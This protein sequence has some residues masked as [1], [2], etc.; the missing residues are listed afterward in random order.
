MRFW[1]AGAVCLLTV[2]LLGLT[3]CGGDDAAEPGS[4]ESGPP[5]S[6]VAG[7]GTAASTDEGTPSGDPLSS[8]TPTDDGGSAPSGRSFTSPDEYFDG[9]QVL[10][11]GSGIYFGTTTVTDEDG[12]LVGQDL[13]TGEESWR[14]PLDS[15]TEATARDRQ[16]VHA[17]D[18]VAVIQSIETEGEGLDGAQESTEVSVYGI[19]DGQQRGQTETIEGRVDHVDWS[20]RRALVPLP[21]IGQKTTLYATTSSG[22]LHGPYKGSDSYAAFLR[23]GEPQSVG[24]YEVDDELG[25]LRPE[26]ADL[27]NDVIFQVTEDRLLRISAPMASATGDYSFVVQVMD[28]ATEPVSEATVCPAKAPYAAGGGGLADP[29]LSPERT[30]A[31]FGP[32]VIKVESGETTCLDDLSDQPLRV[33]ALGDDGSAWVNTD[34]KSGLVDA[35]GELVFTTD[36]ASKPPI[37]LLPDDVFIFSQDNGPITVV[38]RPAD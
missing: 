27:H 30:H 6:A 33:H 21:V 3:A 36:K 25:R 13:L 32:S 12:D 11:D 8:S 28:A 9:A 14:V 26:D 34:D 2:A 16:L 17:G 35:S 18:A 5:A 15:P 7:E 10:S 4:A 23:D 22:T 31:A 19:E 24:Y 20:I 1:S 38:Q 29:V 37:G